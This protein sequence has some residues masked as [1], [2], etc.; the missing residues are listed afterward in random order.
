MTNDN[1]Y[2]KSNPPYKALFDKSPIPIH[3]IDVSDISSQI[4]DLK[5]QGV[6]D[7]YHLKGGILKYLEHVPQHDSKW[8]G[9]CFVFDNRV[10]V[11]HGL[12]EGSFDQCFACR[13]PITEAEKQGP[14]Y[15]RGVQC[16]QCKGEYTDGDRSRFAER[17][18]Q[19]EAGEI[20]GS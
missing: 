8:D 10:S 1:I 18:R 17:Q 14:D 4:A 3:G 16:H 13:R 19:I 9:E 11:G 15:I 2:I 20:P 6:E 5:N 7:V 12:V